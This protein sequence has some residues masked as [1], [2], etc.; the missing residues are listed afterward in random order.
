MKKIIILG[1][2]L[3]SWLSFSSEIKNK[4]KEEKFNF[5]VGGM[6]T[7]NSKLYKVDGKTTKTMPVFSVNYKHLYLVGTEVGY[8][9]RVSKKFALTG[10]TQLFGGM[11]LQGIGGTFGG[12]TLDN[13]EMKDGYTGIDDRKTQ[14][15]GGIRVIYNTGYKAINLTGEA[16]GGANGG[17]VKLSAI[18]PYKINEKFFLFPQANITMFNS[19]MIQYY[20]GITDKEANKHSDDQLTNYDPS[21]YG[22]AAGFGLNG[23]Y[24]FNSRWSTFVITEIQFVSDEIAN[25]PIVDNKTNYSMSIGLMYKI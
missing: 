16:R 6:V 11:T 13:S 5:S 2:M 12:T 19:N 4:N 3:I 20:F 24:N 1:L 21:K 25:S 7:Q 10:F 22:L 8:K 17:S 23:T 18:K 15:E 14:V 9:K